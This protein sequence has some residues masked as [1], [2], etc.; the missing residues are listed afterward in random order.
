VSQAFE[1]AAVLGAA[2][3]MCGASREALRHFEVS[4]RAR[5]KQVM[6]VG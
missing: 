4:R 3:M 5:W 2:V 6:Q 1:D